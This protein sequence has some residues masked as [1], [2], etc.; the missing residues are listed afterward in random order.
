MHILILPSWYP[1]SSHDIGGSFFREQAIALTHYGDQKVGVIYPELRS[2]K[3]FLLWIRKGRKIT[4]TD[5]EG[6]LTYRSFSLYTMPWHLSS[7]RRLFFMQ[8]LLLF[9]QYVKDQ[10]LPDI[11]HVH[12]A[13]NGGLLAREIKRTHGI[14]F[15]LTEHS[16]AYGFGGIGETEKRLAT[17]VVRS[18]DGL[19]AV[20]RKLAMD[21]DSCFGPGMFKWKYIPNMVNQIF[22]DYQCQ[23]REHDRDNFTFVSV[24]LLTPV[25]RIDL[26]LRAFALAF[27]GQR[28]VSLNIIGDGEQLGM[29]RALSVELGVAAN[30]RF[31]GRLSRN[32]VREA[33]ANSDGLVLTSKYETFGVVLVEALALGKPVVATR[34]G[35]PESI[36]REGLDG[37]LVPVG[38][39]TALAHG[40]KRLRYKKAD[41]VPASIRQECAKR[42]GPIAVV[43]QILAEYSTVLGYR[44]PLAA[45][46]GQS[47]LAP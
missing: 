41:F 23:V 14:P 34:C 12:S 25:K 8:G 19:I 31:L 2:I 1:R 42:F 15:L 20:S 9:E 6:V 24:A 30:V 35:G 36:V 47:D 33:V 5:D 10:G 38:D 22:L 37:F 11:V 3:N 17:L 7:V 26:L 13:L 27:R 21:L 44:A 39:E 45:P 46:C 29:L 4:I 16:S 32:D 28:K 43:N 18:A 40:L